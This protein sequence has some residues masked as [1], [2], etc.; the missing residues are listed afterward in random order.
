MS[1]IE[2]YERMVIFYFEKIET[3][4]MALRMNTYMIKKGDMMYANKR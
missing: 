3:K 4:W 1:L 2:E